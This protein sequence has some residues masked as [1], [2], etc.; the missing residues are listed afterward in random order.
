MFIPLIFSMSVL[1]GLHYFNRAEQVY[2]WMVNQPLQYYIWATLFLIFVQI[3]LYIYEKLFPLAQGLYRSMSRIT[4]RIDNLSNSIDKSS[5]D[6]DSSFNNGGR[7]SMSTTS[8][9]RGLSNLNNPFPKIGGGKTK[10]LTRILSSRRIKGLFASIVENGSMVSLDPVFKGHP[11]FGRKLTLEQAKEAEASLVGKGLI[12]KIAGNKDGSFRVLYQ[13]L[14]TASDLIQGFGW[15]VISA[16]FPGKVKF[17]SRMRLLKLF[18]GYIFRMYKVNGSIQ[19]VKYLKASQLAL[20]KAISGDK[21]SNLR[22]LEK[23]VVRS[24]LTSSGL[25]PIIPSR[26]R[27]LIM[28]RGQLNSSVIRF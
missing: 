11:E 4:S 14:G 8:K 24:K 16:C 12:T 25:P 15:R 9:S 5:K 3:S 27:K 21:I 18:S 26:D 6:H 7:R 23:S 13:S 2:T 22:Q 19:V 28:T 10:A 1:V 20:Q 17:S